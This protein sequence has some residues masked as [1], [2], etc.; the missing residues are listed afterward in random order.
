MSVY[1]MHYD[2]VQA[3]DTVFNSI[4][5]LSDLADHAMSPSPIS[6]Q[7]MIDLAH[8]IFAKCAL[9]QPDLQLWNRQPLADRTYANLIQH[10]GDAQSD[11]SSL[12]T[13]AN[14]YHQQPPHN[15][16][17][18]PI[19]DLVLQRLY[20]E[21]AKTPPPVEPAPSVEPAPTADNFTD[22]ANSL[23]R[24]ETERQS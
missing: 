15:A 18:T 4:D 9:L 22:V 11:L 20:D 2:I 13:A 23:Q 3:V 14:V 17:L 24:R 5:D 10:L 7:Q 1:N 16:N 19:A 21:Q 12:P 8:V 6:K